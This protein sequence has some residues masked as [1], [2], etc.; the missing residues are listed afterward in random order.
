M[1]LRAVFQ[2]LHMYQARYALVVT[3]PEDLFSQARDISEPV[4][5]FF[6]HLALTTFLLPDMHEAVREPILAVRAPLIVEDDATNGSGIHPGSS[7]FCHL[8]YALRLSGRYRR[9][10]ASVDA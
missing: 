2:D 5:R 10:L 6:E 1:V 3:G 9:G 4:T 7:L 8:C